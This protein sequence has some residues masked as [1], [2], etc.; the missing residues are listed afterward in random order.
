MATTSNAGSGVRSRPLSGPY[1]CGR[2][3]GGAEPDRGRCAQVARVRGDHHHLLG[4]E[5]EQ[6]GGG[7]VH[8]RVRLV[9]ARQLGGQHRVPRQPGR[10]GHV[11][12]QGHVPVRQR[13]QHVARAQP[14]QALDGVGP[15]AEP[16]PRVVELDALGLAQALEPELR[17]QIVENHAVQIVDLRPRQLAL[18]HPVHGRPVAGPPALGEGVPVAVEPLAG[19]DLAPLARDARPPVDDRA[20]D[21]ERERAHA[22][23]ALGQILRGGGGARLPGGPCAGRHQNAR[24]ETEKPATSIALPHLNNLRRSPDCS[25]RRPVLP[26]GRGRGPAGGRAAARP[27]PAPGPAVTRPAARPPPPPLPP[28]TGCVACAPAPR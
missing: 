15:G 13:G 8:D 2:G 7:P 26:P 16:V 11:D 24:P 18:P 14:R 19:G 10:L 12:E 25:P 20:E 9:G 22:A 21:V 6:I 23:Q 27:A 5:A 28:P 3:V 1:S 17:N 4:R